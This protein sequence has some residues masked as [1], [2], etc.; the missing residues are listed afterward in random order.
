MNTHIFVRN[1]RVLDP[2]P[3]SMEPLNELRAYAWSRDYPNEVDVYRLHLKNEIN[4]TSLR[5]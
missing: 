1:P 5:L 3:L 4:D 2:H